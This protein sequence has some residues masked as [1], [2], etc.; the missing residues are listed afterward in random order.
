MHKN[1]DVFFYCLRPVCNSRVEI[2][3]A[4]RNT[5]KL[6]IIKYYDMSDS[7]NRSQFLA[8]FPEEKYRNWLFPVQAVC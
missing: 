4:D 3:Q 8:F 7:K 1:M 2:G 6:H 5:M